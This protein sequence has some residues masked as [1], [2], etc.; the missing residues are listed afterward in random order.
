MSIVPAVSM[1]TFEKRCAAVLVAPDGPLRRDRRLT[2]HVQEAVVG[3]AVFV[4]LGLDQEKDLF[5]VLV[6]QVVIGI[7]LVVIRGG[8]DDA[9]VADAQRVGREFLE[10]VSSSS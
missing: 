1:V 3:E 2:V 5:A 4:L 6:E 10:H 9:N 7:D 8:D